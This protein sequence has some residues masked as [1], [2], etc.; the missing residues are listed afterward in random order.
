MA[1]YG[2]GDDDVGNGNGLSG[3]AISAY[4]INRTSNSNSCR[5]FTSGRWMCAKCVTTN[6]V[7]VFFQSVSKVSKRFKNKEKSE[8]NEVRSNHLVVVVV[9]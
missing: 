4:L 6:G 5:L 7:T 3:N 1:I 8:T 9:V 2:D